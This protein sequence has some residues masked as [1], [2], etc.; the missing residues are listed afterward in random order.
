MKHKENHQQ[1]FAT[2]I[3]NRLQEAFIANSK[4]HSLE[5]GSDSKIDYSDPKKMQELVVNEVCDELRISNPETRV[6]VTKMLTG[7]IF[8]DQKQ[9]ISSDKIF[10]DLSKRYKEISDPTYKDIFKKQSLFKRAALE[11]VSLV[12]TVAFAVCLNIGWISGVSASVDYDMP[13]GRTAL[14]TGVACSMLVAA[15]AAATVGVGASTLREKDT[16]LADMLNAV[17]KE[18]KKPESRGWINGAWDG[19]QKAMGYR[20]RSG[21]NSSMNL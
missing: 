2:T 18:I 20:G 4:K 11:V 1:D 6:K 5:S 3:L 10:E 17:S 15:A 16:A 14:L 8:N 12:S 9:A 21:G 7:D 13:A 19:V